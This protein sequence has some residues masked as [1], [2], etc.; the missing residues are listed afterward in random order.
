MTEKYD[1]IWDFCD[2]LG[3]QGLAY[4]TLYYGGSKDIKN[5]I[6]RYLGDEDW[7]NR[8]GGDFE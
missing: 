4:E 5:L 3:Y 6:R 8:K 1:I 7:H 2:W